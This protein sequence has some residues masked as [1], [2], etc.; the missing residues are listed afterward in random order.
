MLRPYRKPTFRDQ[1][2]HALDLVGNKEEQCILKKFG[3]ASDLN[4]VRDEHLKRIY[5]EAFNI[6]DEPRRREHDE[7]IRRSE[8]AI[9][10]SDDGKG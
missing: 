1:V 7:W 10:D 3:S 2:R 9:P 8:R 5:D 6:L 4:D